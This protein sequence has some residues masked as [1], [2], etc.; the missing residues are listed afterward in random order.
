MYK[1]MKK[2]I[3]GIMA[4]R[5][6]YIFTATR[7][8]PVFLTYRGKTRTAPHIIFIWKFSDEIEFKAVIT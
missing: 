5:N 2:Y 7:T 1:N 6:L 4:N 3:F 8:I